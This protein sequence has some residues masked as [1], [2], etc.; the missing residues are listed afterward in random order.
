M[1]VCFYTKEEIV[2]HL[3]SN[4]NLLW[5]F[6]GIWLNDLKEADDVIVNMSQKNSKS[7]VFAEAF[8]YMKKI[9]ERRPRFSAFKHCSGK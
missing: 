3:K 4:P 9:L 1:E 8:L 5:G 2:Q 7:N 6:K